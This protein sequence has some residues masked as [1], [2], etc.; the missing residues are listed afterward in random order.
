MRNGEEINNYISR[1]DAIIDESRNLSGWFA[2]KI[3]GMATMSKLIAE[4]AYFREESRGAH[5]RDD[6]PEENENFRVH[7]VNRKGLE[8]YSVKL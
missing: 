4:S 8:P 7:I 1:L 3:L 6:F 2:Y 5:L